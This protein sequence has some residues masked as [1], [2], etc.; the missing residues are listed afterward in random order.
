MYFWIVLTQIML[1]TQ[2]H[3]L[4]PIL[5]CSIT[6]WIP[7]VLGVLASQYPEWGKS[8]PTEELLDQVIV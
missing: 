1:T 3:C 5:P 8:S 6:P 4:D 2:K 7:L